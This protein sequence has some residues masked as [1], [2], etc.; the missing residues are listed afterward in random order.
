MHRMSRSLLAAACALVTGL[1]LVAAPAFARHGEPPYSLANPAKASADVPL[2]DVG[3]VDAAQLRRDADRMQGMPGVREKRQKTAVSRRVSITPDAQ[4]RWDSLDDGSRIWRVRLR[5]VGATD[6]R[7]SFAR[8]ALPRGAT[9]HLIGAGDFYQGPYTNADVQEGA[10]HA[11][12]V[13]G[14][15]ATVE[16][17]VPP[18]ASVGSA[19]LEIDG[20]GAGFRDLF[21]RSKSVGDSGAC[22]VDVACPLGQPYPN[23]IRAV[24]HYEFQAAD[25]S[26]FYIC[27]GTLLTDVPKDKR[28]YFLTAHHCMSAAS[29][30]Q[31]MIVYWNYEST[32]CGSD[33]AP[34]G[35]F[36]NDDQHGATLRAT[37]ADTDFT[38]VEL[39]GTPDTDWN[40]YYAGW[41]ASGIAPGGTI[42]IHHP[43]GDVKK[44]TAGPRPTT[45]DG[46]ISTTNGSSTHWHAGPYS[47]GTT[48]GG[49]SGSGLF[50]A[51]GSLS[52]DRR[53]IGTL[54]G[55]S[56]LCSDVSPTQPND[57][58]DCY[59]KLS[60]GWNG[61]SAASRLRDWLDP[62]GT[63]ATTAAGVDQNETTQTGV[64]GHSTHA[65]PEILRQLPPPD[66]GAHRSLR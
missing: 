10:F 27:S 41:D 23:E 50:S 36:F 8:F 17:R 56:A 16:L 25:G 28:N 11:P 58:Y 57:G 13:P 4:G 22:N 3:G 62:A 9:L 40:L 59:G 65:L 52:P 39:T 5:A 1:A 34:P 64:P 38:L 63:G 29:E 19:Q 35:G 12:V 42:G 31:S 46:C 49:S 60:V 48:E 33:V 54:S 51:A 53:L 66:S 37:R 14:D 21:K 6:I 30:A 32:Q 24:G 61:S 7:L 26:G 15:T 2:E 55:G 43:S 18:R 45:I 47:Q 20:V 44:I